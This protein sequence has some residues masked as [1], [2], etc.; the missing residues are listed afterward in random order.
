LEEIKNAVTILKSLGLEKSQAFY[1]GRGS[2]EECTR[3][4]AYME[5]KV[6]LIA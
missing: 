5:N 2:K 3:P 6:L 1:L 4:N